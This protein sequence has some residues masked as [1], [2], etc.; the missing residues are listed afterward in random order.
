MSIF[1]Q[2]IHEKD[3]ERILFDVIASSAYNQHNQRCVK[4]NWAFSSRGCNALAFWTWESF[5]KTKKVPRYINVNNSQMKHEGQKSVISQSTSLMAIDRCIPITIRRVKKRRYNCTPRLVDHERVGSARTMLFHPR[6][7][8]PLNRN[9]HWYQKA[10]YWTIGQ[11]KKK[12]RWNLQCKTN[13]AA[14]KEYN[15]QKRGG[16]SFCTFNWRPWSSDSFR[17]SASWTASDW[18]NSTYA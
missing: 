14:E 5:C 12:R 1:T 15:S 11:N 18:R 7:I 8:G 9:L 13:S 17:W 10:I 2:H 6:Y 3:K 4:Q 16:K